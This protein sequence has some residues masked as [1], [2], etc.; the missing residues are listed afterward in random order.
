MYCELGLNVHTCVPYTG[1][2]YCFQ[3]FLLIYKNAWN[4]I[5]L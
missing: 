3:T 4:E 5:S 2:D 1:F